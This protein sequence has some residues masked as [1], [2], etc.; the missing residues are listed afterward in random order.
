MRVL[1]HP[2]GLQRLASET[3]IEALDQLALV[4]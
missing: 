3:V 1:R 4:K 2:G